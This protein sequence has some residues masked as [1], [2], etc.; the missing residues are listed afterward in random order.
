MA[1]LVIFFV[2]LVTFASW[3]LS[4]TLAVID[5]EAFYDLSTMFYV[6]LFA[7]TFLRLPF[8]KLL[9]LPNLDFGFFSSTL[10]TFA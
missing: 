9:N 5:F 3:L 4:I 2:T 6:S 1:V 8:P 7:P 10:S